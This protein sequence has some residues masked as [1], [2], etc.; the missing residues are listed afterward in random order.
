MEVGEEEGEGE[1][2]G[3]KPAR[4]VSVFN[5]YSMPMNAL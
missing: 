1:V 3:T 5:Y 2:G 4:Y